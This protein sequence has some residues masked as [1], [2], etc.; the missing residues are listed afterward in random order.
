MPDENPTRDATRELW[1]AQRAVVLQV[2]RDD[3]PVQWTL[4]EL[5]AQISDIPQQALLSA[6]LHLAIEEVLTFDEESIRASRCARHMDLLELV[7]V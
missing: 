2:L 1:A 3:H 6:L 5:E 7:S 4:A